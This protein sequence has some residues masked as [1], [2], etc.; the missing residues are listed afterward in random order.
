MLLS[1]CTKTPPEEPQTTETTEIEEST[2]EE[3]TEETTVEPTETPEPSL[4]S[5]YKNDEGYKVA[6]NVLKYIQEND[7]N[8][9]IKYI[10][11][12]EN[13]I[14]TG[15]N[16]L[17]YM[18]KKEVSLMVGNP[19]AQIFRF[20][21]GQTFSTAGIKCGDM[22]F[23]LNLQNF[24][25]EWR[26]LF[27]DIIQEN[28]TIMA[29]GDVEIILN[30]VKLNR[31]DAVYCKETDDGRVIY[32]LS[33]PNDTIEATIKS[34]FFGSYKTTMKRR[35]NTDIAEYTITGSLT[36][37]QAEDA[38]NGFKE[39]FNQLISEGFTRDLTEDGLIEFD[40][41]EI[42]KKYFS[43]SIDDETVN[44]FIEWITRTRN[45]ETTIKDV[46]ISEVKQRDSQSSF[47]CSNNIVMLNIGY[48]LAWNTSENDDP[49]FETSRHLCSVFL[50]RQQDGS[51]KIYRTTNIFQ[52]TNFEKTVSQY[53]A[54]E[55]EFKFPGYKVRELP[56]EPETTET[57]QD[58]EPTTEEH[59]GITG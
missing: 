9:I 35:S 30:G 53:E 25:G 45:A 43:S 51:F 8:E 42:V 38:M 48:E 27:P 24:D 18:T 59:H 1:G 39:I 57:T 55:K 3:E 32:T 34:D 26:L 41:E 5:L 12:P 15:K 14:L 31:D 13:A 54:I 2:T 16:F 36:D 40:R 29:P 19:S 10:D 6:K 46:Y 33:I 44:N 11:L 4:D 28:A 58:P 37:K 21:Q 50:E 47:I 20:Q 49:H 7:L 56:E 23:L 52:D 22:Q 17:S